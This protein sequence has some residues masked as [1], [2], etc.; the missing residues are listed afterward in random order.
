VSFPFLNEKKE[1]PNLKNKI[2]KKMKK[3]KKKYYLI[4]PTH[5]NLTSLNPKP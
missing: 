3:K 5:L 4:I 2:I 1:N